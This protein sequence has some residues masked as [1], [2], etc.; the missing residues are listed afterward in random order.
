MVLPPLRVNGERWIAVGSGLYI[1]AGCWLQ[2]SPLSPPPIPSSK[3]AMTAVSP[4]AM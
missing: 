2:A 4:E 3:L 1:G